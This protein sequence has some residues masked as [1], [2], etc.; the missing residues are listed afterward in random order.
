[1]QKQNEKAVLRIRIER[2]PTSSQSSERSQS[3][4]VPSRN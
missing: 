3:D 4:V 1:M 2:S